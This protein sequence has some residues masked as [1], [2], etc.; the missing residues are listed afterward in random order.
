MDNH[1]Q[2]LSGN[3]RMNSA[4]L[5]EHQILEAPKADKTLTELALVKV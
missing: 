3:Q 2:R 5:G 1:H 4:K